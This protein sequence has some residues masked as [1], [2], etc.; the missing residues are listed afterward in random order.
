MHPRKQAK[1]FANMRQNDHYQASGAKQ[2]Q[3][4]ARTLL[5]EE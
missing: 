1:R 4:G 5:S 2:L 3:Y